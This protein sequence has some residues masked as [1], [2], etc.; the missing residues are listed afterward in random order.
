MVIF[1]CGLGMNRTRKF[2]KLVCV[3]VFAAFS[4]SAVVAQEL[5]A[6]PQP[7]KKDIGGGILTSNTT[8]EFPPLSREAI[9]YIFDSLR[10]GSQFNLPP[11]R[12]S[13][14]VSNNIVG[15]WAGVKSGFESNVGVI[16]LRFR[17]SDEARLAQAA[18]PKGAAVLADSF[19]VE[20]ELS[21]IDFNI[22]HKLAESNKAR[23]GM[24][25]KLDEQ[26]PNQV[27]IE[28]VK[29]YRDAGMYF[30]W[31]PVVK[32]AAYNAWALLVCPRTPKF[33]QQRRGDEPR[34]ELHQSPYQL[35]EVHFEVTGVAKARIPPTD[36][37][38]RV[39]VRV[40]AS[41]NLPRAAMNS[42]E[43]SS[44]YPNLEVLYRP[45]AL[46]EFFR[47]PLLSGGIQEGLLTRIETENPA[48]YIRRQ[49]QSHVVY[50]QRLQEPSPVSVI[51]GEYKASRDEGECYVVSVQRSVWN[52]YD[53]VG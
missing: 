20:L 24:Q 53:R 41:E 43:V 1:S 6:T 16:T 17:P 37:P 32:Q 12:Q 33:V 51:I 4:S 47:I 30:A 2:L 45:Q 27:L 26:R 13:Q 22:R 14:Q 52:E 49:Y 18:A 8:V 15:I 28:F 35:R 11:L 34:L 21:R 36:K 44:L 9:D 19:D 29:G 31:P 5:P 46:F 38:E 25:V 10:S 40:M 7:D 3:G 48:G 50:V 39:A 23:Q 42:D